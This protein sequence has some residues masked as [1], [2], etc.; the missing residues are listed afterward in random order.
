MSESKFF[1]V[2][3]ADTVE[4][5]SRPSDDDDVFTISKDPKKTGWNNDDDCPGYG[6][7]KQDALELANSAND[8]NRYKSLAEKHLS[9]AKALAE[10][11]KKVAKYHAFVPDAVAV[12]E[13]DAALSLAREMGVGK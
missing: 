6:L 12:L 9:V 5:Y 11:G 1:V 8:C 13:L 3:Y 7:T 10:A 2:C 4:N